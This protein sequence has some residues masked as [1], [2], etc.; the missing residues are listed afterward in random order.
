LGYI[1]NSG[2]SVNREYTPGSD[3][4]AALRPG[5]AGQRPP[6]DPPPPPERGAAPPTVALREAVR[7]IRKAR[8]KRARTEEHI[9]VRYGF[10][11][12]TCPGGAEKLVNKYMAAANTTHPN[13]LEAEKPSS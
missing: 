10:G 2:C 5:P 3:E 6:G 9:P 13:T 12:Y 4:V 11:F 1:I 7:R 8:L